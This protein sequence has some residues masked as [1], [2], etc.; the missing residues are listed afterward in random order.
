[1][2]SMPLSLL[3]A[4]LP[5]SAGALLLAACGGGNDGGSPLQPNT[6]TPPAPYA[7]CS[8]AG[9]AA[10][11]ASAATVTVCMLTTQG[12]IVVGLNPVNAPVTVDN[13]LR[14]VA[15]GHYTNT[16][17]HRV[18]S[19]FVIQGGGYAAVLSQG[20]TANP[21][22]K[23]T[24]APIVLESNN[25]LKNLRGAIAMARTAQPNTATAQFYLN[26]VANPC[27]DYGNTCAGG[28]PNGYAV[29]GSII[30]GMDVLD[31]IRA[32]ATDVNDRPRQDV[33]TYWA[34]KLKG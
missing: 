12:E 33:V 22:E 5:V 13:F 27:L 32:V 23:P 25:G 29:F 26:T 31:K 3:R 15:A 11:D 21:V 8:A 30:A 4:L 28:D 1:M 17:Y 9:K 6:P 16:L 20:F 2:L 19:N 18:I 7:S 14:Y 10:S 24:F 34:E